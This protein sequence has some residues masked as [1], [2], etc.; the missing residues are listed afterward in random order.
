MAIS[1]LAAAQQSERAVTNIGPFTV[2]GLQ[3]YVGDKIFWMDCLMVKQMGS[4]SFQTAYEYCADRFGNQHRMDIDQ[5]QDPTPLQLSARGNVERMHQLYRIWEFS[6]SRNCGVNMYVAQR[7]CI[8]P[9]LV[10]N[11]NFFKRGFW[12]YNMQAT[13]RWTFGND[14]IA[15]DNSKTP[16]IA[17]DQG[18]FL[19]GSL[20]VSMQY[21]YSQVNAALPGAG[22]DEMVVVDAGQCNTGNS[23]CGCPTP[24]GQMVIGIKSGVANVQMSTDGGKNFAA[25]T[26]GAGTDLAHSI[27]TKDG[28]VIFTTRLAADQTLKFWVGIPNALFTGITFTQA[29]FASGTP[30]DPQATNPGQKGNSV[31]D[32]QYGGML[33]AGKGGEVYLSENYG[34]NWKRIAA[35]VTVTTTVARVVDFYS[36]SRVGSIIYGV[37]YGATGTDLIFVHSENGGVDWTLDGY[38]T[39]GASPT[40]VKQYNLGDK[41]FAN[42]DGVVYRF[43]CGS[44]SAALN[45]AGFAISN[46]LMPNPASANDVLVLSRGGVLHRTMDQFATTANEASQLGSL[47]TTLAGTNALSAWAYSRGQYSDRILFSHGAGL[48]AAQEVGAPFS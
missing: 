39:L 34:S 17:E 2:V 5:V 8:K 32:D 43:D 33:W 1:Q 25:V 31:T 4:D 36:L 38:A 26:V 47:A 24:G 6:R 20:G 21:K 11:P 40:I 45:P 48:Y 12:V 22:F 27:A 29:T 14:T 46:N 10:N 3:R 7:D 42:V 15:G 37:G 16:Q 35:G 18:Q 13:G 19:P 28:V 44:V 41:N 23:K 30:T 9:N